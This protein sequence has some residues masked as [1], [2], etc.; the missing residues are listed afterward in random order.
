MKR[1]VRRTDNLQRLAA[2]PVTIFFVCFT[3][4]LLTVGDRWSIAAK[5]SA[6]SLALAVFVIVRIGRG[7]AGP[8][9]VRA[10]AIFF[11]IP[12][13]L[14]GAAERMGCAQKQ[15]TLKES[16]KD[17]RSST[18]CSFSGIISD[19]SIDNDKIMI[20]IKNAHVTGG[21]F[22]AAKDTCGSIKV[23][24]NPKFFTE[25]VSTDVTA[26]KELSDTYGLKK[27][28]IGDMAVGYGKLRAPATAANPGGFDEEAYYTSR[29]IDALL[30]ASGISITEMS[31]DFFT[32]IRRFLTNLRIGSI[33][34]LKENLRSEEASVL[35]AVLTGERGLISDDTRDVLSDGGIAHILAVSGLHISLIAGGLY[36]IIIKLTSRKRLSCF[37]VIFVLILYGI[38]TG[39]PVSAARAIIMSC[40][41]LIGRSFGKTYDIMS[42]LSLAGLIILFV[43]P[44]CVRD[45]SFVMSFCAAGGAACGRE[46]C[47]GLKIRK[48]KLVSVFTVGSIYLFL[49]PVLIN[50]YYCVTPYSVLINLIVVPLMSLL[51][52]FGSLCVFCSAILG[53]GAAGFTGGVCHYII[54]IMMFLGELSRKLPFGKIVTG[55]KDS[56]IIVFY[57]AVILL[58]IV[59]AMTFRRKKVLFL[60]GLCAL[61]FV[62]I[63]PAGTT[64]HMLDVGQGECIVIEDGD[65][66]LIVDMGSSN[67]SKLYKYRV[68]P[69]LRFMGIDTIDRI[70]LTHSDSDH[71]NGM[72]DLFSDNDIC[73]K[74]FICSDTEDGTVAQKELSTE[75]CEIRKVAA[76][77]VIELNSG[78]I[79]KV[80][81]P[82]RSLKKEDGNGS[83][84][85]IAVADKN[86]MSIVFE[87]IGEYF[88][89][90]FTGDS[91]SKTEAEYISRLG[92]EKTDILKVAHHGSKYSTSYQLLERTK[93]LIGIISASATNRY[94]HPS[95]DTLERLSSIGCTGYD[96]AKCG[97]IRIFCSG[98]SISV[99]TFKKITTT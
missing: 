25:Y 64:V 61:I 75:T 43:N 18:E 16:L 65:E 62:R 92:D 48:R 94:G 19:I 58:V 60:L 51:V 21:S 69:F 56:G 98:G 96:T 41:M 26:G 37:T 83:E 24:C 86:D 20:F 49:L 88:T 77:D 95:P 27:T 36:G 74:E 85:R 73:V 59:L 82:A 3:L 91:S 72:E 23:T 44:L 42:A 84:G 33:E 89:G 32:G 80:L 4:T 99:S 57:Y 2:R 13:F 5:G 35:A 39:M 97:Y 46:L 66:N 6:V 9:S 12:V 15:S 8:T 53:T 79:L 29:G 50:T 45:S 67:V 28:G 7:R 14:F 52:P 71:K 31:V 22:Y 93:P 87:Y 68:E 11:L 63:K 47:C 30:T 10:A 90:L 55:H 34:A 1:R 54:K 17:L 78:S 70:I 76:G 81:S 38:F 40:C